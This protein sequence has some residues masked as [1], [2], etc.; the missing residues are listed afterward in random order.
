[1]LPFPAAFSINPAK[2][3]P[4][5]SVLYNRAMKQSSLLWLMIGLLIGAATPAWAQSQGRTA[6]GPVGASMAVLATLQDAGVLPPEGT[7]EANRVIQVV[8]QF[9]A[10]FMKSSDPALREFFDQALAAKWTD[11]AEQI[12]AGFRARGWTSEIVEALCGYYATR[13][14]QQRARL[15]EAFAQFNMRLA[16]FEL[17]S[18]LFGKARAR[19]SQRGQ[20]IHQI[21]ATHRRSMPGGKRDDRKETRDGDQGVYSHQS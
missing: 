9:Q 20:D 12:G 21:F 19:F 3:V 8:I 18:D 17:L 6:T 15:T 16:D 7:P 1:M 13:S 4:S 10:A 14:E 2:L 5:G 11:Q